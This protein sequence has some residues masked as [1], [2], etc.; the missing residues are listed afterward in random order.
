MRE[1]EKNPHIL[2]KRLNKLIEMGLI[3]ERTHPKDRRKKIYLAK[4]EEKIK[5]VFW[6]NVRASI[7]DKFGSYK[8]TMYPKDSESTATMSFIYTLDEDIF[9]DKGSIYFL[10]ETED[11]YK[12]YQFNLSPIEI[13]DII[14]DDMRLSEVLKEAE[15]F[16]DAERR[17]RNF[18]MK[19]KKGEIVVQMRPPIRIMKGE[20][21][22]FQ[23]DPA[24]VK[25]LYEKFGSVLGRYLLKKT[26]DLVIDV[27][28]SEEDLIK[29]FEKIKIGEE[30][31]YD[32]RILIARFPKKVVEKYGSKELGR[33]LAVYA[34][35]FKEAVEKGGFVVVMHIDLK[36]TKKLSTLA[37]ILKKEPPDLLLEAI[38]CFYNKFV[39]ETMKLGKESSEKAE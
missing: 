14:S 19:H 16:H 23:V 32:P 4:N 9:G 29:G 30:V 2:R 24:Q 15:S 1:I 18:M 26:M 8:Y 37:K 25:K 12:L 3:E 27:L 11:G 36:R 38:D 7:L 39:E 28:T 17:I 34:R 6:E 10:D 21:P 33:L 13:I 35:A 5:Q 31:T 22:V 20:A